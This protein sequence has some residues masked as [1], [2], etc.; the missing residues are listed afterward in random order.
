MLELQ[1]I[2]AR[3][4]Q[5]KYERRQDENE[6]SQQHTATDELAGIK[7][8]PQREP[9]PAAKPTWMQHRANRHE[10]E[11]REQDAPNIRR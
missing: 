9:I 8:Q 5:H 6:E 1:R 2:L 10:T 3:Q 4:P 11:Q 7:S